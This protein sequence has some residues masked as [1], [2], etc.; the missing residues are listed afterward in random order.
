MENKTAQIPSILGVST[1]SDSH[2]Y[3]SLFLPPANEVW[4]KVM[5]SLECHSDPRGVSIQGGLCS[6]WG[7]L[8]RGV[9]IGD[10]CR[11]VSVGRSLS[12]GLCLGVSIGE[13]PHSCSLNKMIYLQM[14]ASKVLFAQTTTDASPKSE[15]VMGILTVRMGRMNSPVSGWE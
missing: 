12:R 15:C 14:I 4:G 13:T 8:S 6:V 11:G 9:S 5:F 1:D 3:L 2:E 10:L 7:S